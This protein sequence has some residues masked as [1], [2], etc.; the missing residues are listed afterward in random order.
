MAFKIPLAFSTLG[1]SERMAVE[2]VMASGNVTQGQK[3]AEFERA[4][5]A[6][7][8]VAHA[9]FVNSGSSA[10][11]IAVEAA[12]YL[13]RLR[14]DLVHGAI[15]PG[16]EVIIQGLNWPSTLTPMLNRGLRPVFCDVSLNSLNAGIAEI[17]AVRTERTKMVV[18]VPVLGNPTYLEELR[19]YCAENSLLLL[20]D[21]CE[22][23]GATTKGGALVGTLGLAASFSF[24]FSHHITTIEGGAV[25]TD[26]PHMADLCYALRAH[27]WSRG[28]QLESFLDFDSSAIDPRFCFVIPGYNV[29]STEVNAAIG[30]VQLDRLD[31]MIRCRRT[32][33]AGRIAAIAGLEDKLVIPGAD[34]VD[35]HSWMTTPLLFSDRA[36]R[37]RGQKMLEEAGVETRPI[38]VGNMLRHP[39]A[40]MLDLPEHQPELPNCDEV[41]NRGLMIGLSPLSTAE[42]EEIV[43]SALAQAARA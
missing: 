27:G 10:N 6:K 43:C 25:L 20:E 21:A 31:D 18:A 13:S 19:D 30:L 28:L 29:R 26:D 2:T 17:E 5:A 22:S 33:A 38:I 41:F 34:I 16:D 36:H 14:P 3:V 37:E 8:G 7:H 35:R 15:N 39:L 4:L 11:L 1:D 42:D 40:R 23:I 12:T 32:I 24:Y 9:I